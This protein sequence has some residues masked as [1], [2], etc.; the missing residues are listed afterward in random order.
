[1]ELRDLLFLFLLDLSYDTCFRCDD[2]DT[3][4]DGDAASENAVNLV[5]GVI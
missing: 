1:M 5:E 3:N 4:D 2:F